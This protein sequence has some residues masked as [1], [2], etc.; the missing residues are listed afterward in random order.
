MLRAVDC[1]ARRHDD[2]DGKEK[3]P[4]WAAR[5]QERTAGTMSMFIVIIIDACIIWVYHYLDI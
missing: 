5:R 2:I 1:S 4:T 3:A